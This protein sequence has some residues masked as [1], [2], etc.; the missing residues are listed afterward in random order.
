[1]GNWNFDGASPGMQGT[2]VAVVSLLTFAAVAS[3]GARVRSGC[4]CFCGPRPLGIR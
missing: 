4:R 2:M 3:P 1:L